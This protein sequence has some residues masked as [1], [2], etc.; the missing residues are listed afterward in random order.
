MRAAVPTR[1]VHLVPILF[2]VAGRDREPNHAAQKYR[3]VERL[4]AIDREINLLSTQRLRTDELI[5]GASRASY[6]ATVKDIH[7]Y[8]VASCQGCVGELT[9]RS[10]F[11]HSAE[12]KLRRLYPDLRY[13]LPDYCCV[14]YPGSSYR[15]TD[16]FIEYMQAVSECRAV[17]FAEQN[18]LEIGIDLR[19]RCIDCSWNAAPPDRW[20][21]EI[22]IPLVGG[23]ALD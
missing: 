16:I 9:D 18:S 12:K 22:Q 17:K 10:D 13:A 15:E 20:L 19:E 8:T 3:D 14:I 1:R 5:S 2:S 21:T 11:V 6:T 4:D 23:D 7:E